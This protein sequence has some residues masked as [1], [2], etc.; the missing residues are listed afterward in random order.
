MK[1]WDVFISHASEDKETVVLPLCAALRRAG[2]KV[3]LDR[4]ELH[5][6]DSLREKIDEGLA[7]SRFGVV[8]LS[9]SFMAKGWPRRELNGLM[10]VEESGQKVILPIWHQID[11]QTLAEYSPILADRLA[12]DT[13]RGI[14]EVASQIVAVV[15]QRESGSPS[16]ESPTLVRRL[17]EVL[18]TDPNSSVIKEF[19]S[20]YPQIATRALGA[21][22]SEP[23]LWSVKMS[24]FALDLCVEKLLQ[25]TVGS[26][27][28]CI[29]QFDR[30]MRPLFNSNLDPTPEIAARVNEM[31]VLRR[32]VGKNLGQARQVLPRIAPNFHCTVVSGRRASLSPQE[33]ERLRE[34]NDQL[35]GIQVRTYDFLIDAAITI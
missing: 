14:Q 26:R 29:V 8:V 12:A 28:W 20:S 5:L 27:M 25:A 19:L 18:D 9:P 30:S 23:V 13:S 21:Q 16:V 6:G 11:K 3:W 4:Q 34:Y 7:N 24:D 17:V 31:E 33:V 32:W 1:Q 22:Q 15:V 10:A 35:L 2:L